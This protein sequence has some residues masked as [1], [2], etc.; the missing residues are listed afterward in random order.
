MPLL[1]IQ[2]LGE[3]KL[4]NP[5]LWGKSDSVAAALNRAKSYFLL[6]SMVSDSFTFGL[7]PRLLG[8]H[9]EDVPDR[10]MSRERVDLSEAEEEERAIDEQIAADEE[11][12]LLPRAMTKVKVRSEMWL[13]RTLQPIW[14]SLPHWAR[15][16]FH[17]TGT[18]VSAPLVGTLIG[19]AIGLIPP[20]KDAF[21]GDS[22]HGGIFRAWFTISVQNIGGLFPP[23]QVSLGYTIMA[24][25]HLLKRRGCRGWCEVER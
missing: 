8:A 11:T 16:F 19:V 5:I 15:T 10:V 1:L 23:L 7:G 18:F 17:A 9:E 25:Y 6:N 3:T 2:S 13:V 12:S 20:L 21:F 24:L 22:E 4:L 14:N